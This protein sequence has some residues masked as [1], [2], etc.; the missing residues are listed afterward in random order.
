[1]SL[2]ITVYEI[3]D[4]TS[5]CFITDENPEQ[6][7]AQQ[8]EAPVEQLPEAPVEQLPEA[9]VEQLPEAP[10]EQLPE[11][12]AQEKRVRLLP[13]ERG[14][15]ATKEILPER[16]I[17]LLR[18]LKEKRNNIQEHPAYDPEASELEHLRRIQERRSKREQQEEKK[19]NSKG[20]S[21]LELEIE[22]ILL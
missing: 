21:D 13:S 16:L 15:A 17:N 3:L 10:V 22:Q 6:A 8:P 7:P 2:K 11:A 20:L 5:I 1:M 9:P 14:L 18:E 19:S 12:P 4:S